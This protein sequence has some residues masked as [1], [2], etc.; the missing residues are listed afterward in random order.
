VKICLVSQ[1]YPP[2]STGGIGTQTFLKAHGLAAAGHDVHVVTSSRESAEP[3]GDGEVTVHGVP[4]AGDSPFHDSSLQWIVHSQAVAARL[5]E[6]GEHERFD[7]IE[8]AEYQAEG[9]AYELETYGYRETPVVVMLHGSLAMFVERTGWPLPGTPLAHFGTFMEHTVV[10]RADVLLAASKNIADFWT[11]RGVVEPNR[12]RLVRTAVNTAAFVP[13]AEAP[14]GGAT[15]LFVGRIDGEKGVFAAVEAVAAL[16]PKHPDLRCRIV[17]RGSR[18][19][20]EALDRMI[21]ASP[22]PAAFEVLGHV[23]HERL[24]EVYAACD[25]FVA[26]APRDHG[27]AGVYLEA[28]ACAR[29]VIASRAGGA[30]EAVLD[31][32]TGLLVPPDD[33]D[34]LAGALDRLLADDELRDRMGRAG[35]ERAVAEFSVERLVE[36]CLAAYESAADAAVVG[37]R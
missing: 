28:M 29:P 15:V 14:A 2:W 18:E 32:A 27:V 3:T 34:A 5:L 22:N 1:E 11:A 10:R 24:P 23:G 4:H 30:P 31:G 26:P 25:V 21:A 19:D 35:R 17:G 20:E 7:V 13:P 6:L 9:F 37:R 36:R 12:V 8:F 33:R 16:L